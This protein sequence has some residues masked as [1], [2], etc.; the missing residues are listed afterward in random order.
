MY[1]LR[2]YPARI[3]LDRFYRAIDAE[4]VVR[5]N[6]ESIA[7]HTVI[8]SIQAITP[9]VRRGVLPAVRPVDQPG[10]GG[11]VH[12]RHARESPLVALRVVTPPPSAVVLH[13]ID[14]T[15]LWEHAPRLPGP[16]ASRWRSRTGSWGR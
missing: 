12:R 10:A 16:T 5:G 13:G 14:E 3:P 4:E 1:D 7:G 15:A 9:A 11:D 6:R 2:E 8:D